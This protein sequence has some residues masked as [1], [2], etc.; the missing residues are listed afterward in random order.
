M[1]L[2]ISANWISCRYHALNVSEG[3]AAKERWEL[4]NRDVAEVFLNP[5][6]EWQHGPDS[7]MGQQ[8][9]GCI[10]RSLKWHPII[11]SVRLI[12]FVRAAG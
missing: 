9:F 6:P 4:W 1:L 8:Q 12:S 7:R 2:R 5:Q 10:T 11:L 3:E